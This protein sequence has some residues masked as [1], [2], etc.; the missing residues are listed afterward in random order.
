M[1][2]HKIYQS[3][4]VFCL[5]RVL[6]MHLAPFDWNISISDATGANGFHVFELASIVAVF[7]TSIP[8]IKSISKSC[9]SSSITF[10]WNF[11]FFASSL[12]TTICKS[13]PLS[14]L[15]APA[16]TR[17]LFPCVHFCLPKSTPLTT[18]RHLKKKTGHESHFIKNLS[19]CL[20]VMSKW[21]FK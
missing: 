9:H 20:I 18:A 16:V 13:S 19:S 12:S 17:K 6:V 11:Y 21:S 4:S 15:R 8:H 7:L 2:I 5:Y 14:S 3:P 10:L 1:I